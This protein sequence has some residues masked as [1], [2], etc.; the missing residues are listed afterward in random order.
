[1]GKKVKIDRVAHECA[2]FK[3]QFVSTPAAF[4]FVADT[5]GQQREPIS[6]LMKW[7]QNTWL[8]IWTSSRIPS[9]EYYSLFTIDRV[10]CV[11][12]Y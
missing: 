9:R 4:S 6:C 1:M 11:T 8:E 12:R 2:P 3:L 10:L 5:V 7:K